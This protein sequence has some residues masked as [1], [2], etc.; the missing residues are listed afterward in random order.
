LKFL[1]KHIFWGLWVFLFLSGIQKAATGSSSLKKVKYNYLLHIPE[2]YAK[3]PDRKWPVIFYLHGRH[4]SG[5]NLKSVERY[6]LPY[7]LMNGKKLDFI[8]VSPQCPW[9]KNWASDNWFDPVYDE[10]ASKLRLDEN[11]VYL[12]GMSMGGFGTWELANRM[13][14]RFAAISPMCGGGKAEWADNL[15]KIPTWVFHGT[16]DRQIPISRSEIMVKALESRRANVKFTRLK[17]Q[18][19]DISKA[20]DNDELYRWLGQFSLARKPFWEESLP[21]M[22]SIAVQKVE[23]H[24]PLKSSENLVSVR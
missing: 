8:V 12:I 14:D 1:R 2:D 21:F 15:S 19:H 10:V 4:A 7:Y 20:F 22:K 16:A 18:G 13:P 5:K 9:G 17:N 3:Y 6:G 23:V 11:R 24:S